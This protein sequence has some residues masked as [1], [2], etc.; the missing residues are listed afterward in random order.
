MHSSENI[1][2]SKKFLLQYPDVLFDGYALQPNGN[3]PLG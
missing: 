3:I 2:L 1:I